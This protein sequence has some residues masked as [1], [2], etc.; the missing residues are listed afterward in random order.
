VTLLVL[1]RV[2]LPPA[3]GCG[4]FEVFLQVVFLIDTQVR[5]FAGR[6]GTECFPGRSLR[7]PRCVLQPMGV[8]RQDAHGVDTRVDAWGGD[9]RQD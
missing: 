5:V 7:P 9:R 1:I 2:V 3:V 8:F 6:A 4:L